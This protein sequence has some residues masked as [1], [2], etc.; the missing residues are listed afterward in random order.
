MTSTTKNAPELLS[1]QAGEFE[2]VNTDPT[3]H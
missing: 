2:S 1:R 3:K